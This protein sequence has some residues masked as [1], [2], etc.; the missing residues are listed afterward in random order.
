[1]MLCSVAMS[2]AIGASRR[3]GADDG[4]AVGG[5]GCCCGVVRLSRAEVKGGWEE[6]VRVAKLRSVSLSVLENE[7]RLSVR[8]ELLSLVEVELLLDVGGG[9]MSVKR[10]IND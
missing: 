7:S 2:C 9:G 6:I 5:I 4:A 3:F 1:M 10:S 8:S